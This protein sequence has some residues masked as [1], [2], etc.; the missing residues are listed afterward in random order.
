MAGNATFRVWIVAT[1]TLAISA[2]LLAAPATTVAPTTQSVGDHSKLPSLTAQGNSPSGPSKVEVGVHVLRLMDLD[3]TNN[4]FTLD[5]WIWFRWT[6]DKLKPYE[7]FELVNGKIDSRQIDRV[8]TVNG[9][10]YACLRIQATMSCFWCVDRFPLSRQCLTME[11]EDNDI[12]SSDLVYIVDRENC[13]VEPGLRT[14]GWVYTGLSASSLIHDYATNYGDPRR[15]KGQGTHYSRLAFSYEVGRPDI[16]HSLKIFWG[17]YL[18][19]LV[20][21]TVFFVKPDHRLGL[22]V[23]AIFAVVGSHTFASSY[24]PDAGTLTLADK[25]HMVAAGMI[26]AALFETAYAL[27]LLHGNREAAYRRL[28]RI[29]FCITAPLFVLA[30]I[31][32]LW[33]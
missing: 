26:L 1:M 25:L 32:L 15:A 23:G 2:L 18:S 14:N 8:D 17:L 7:T 10:H 28:D 19:A 5:F 20:A 11:M 12:E 3:I 27:H 29:T 13:S 4:A 31:W 16:F 21:F 6:D 33:P 24:L 30:N 9:V 22:I